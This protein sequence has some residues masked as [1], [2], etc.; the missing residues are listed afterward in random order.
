[1]GDGGQVDKERK[2]GIEV[3]E[4]V[5]RPLMWLNNSF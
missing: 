5:T 1:M 4:D 3:A 2:T